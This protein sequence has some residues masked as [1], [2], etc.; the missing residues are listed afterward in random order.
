MILHTKKTSGSGKNDTNRDG[1]L[2]GQCPAITDF[3]KASTQG[4]NSVMD[5]AWQ[6]A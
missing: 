6:E 2:P 4:H 5:A 3:M 1:V